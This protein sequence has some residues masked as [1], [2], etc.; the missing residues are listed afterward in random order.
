MLIIYNPNKPEF[1]IIIQFDYKSLTTS[2]AWGPTSDWKG[3]GRRI[4]N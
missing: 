1:L 2:L 4:S 3:R